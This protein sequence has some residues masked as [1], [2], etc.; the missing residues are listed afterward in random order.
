MILGRIQLLVPIVEE[1]HV[2]ADGAASGV[3]PRPETDGIRLAH[4]DRHGR[5]TARRAFRRRF[6]QNPQAEFTA[7]RRLLDDGDHLA[8]IPSVALLFKITV[9]QINGGFGGKRSC[10][11]Q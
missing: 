3:V 11:Q 2:D 5:R 1:L 7:V 4:R 9:L 6:I 8:V 10:Q